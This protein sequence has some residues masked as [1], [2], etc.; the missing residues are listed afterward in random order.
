MLK[1]GL[2]VG[3]T[4]FGALAACGDDDSASGPTNGTTDG[5]V[6]KPN[7]A[8]VVADAGGGGIDAGPSPVLCPSTTPFVIEGPVAELNSDADESGL[9]LTADELTAYFERDK[10]IW[11]ASRPDKNAAF[12]NVVKVEVVNYGRSR[13]PMIARDGKTLYFYSDRDVAGYNFLY[14]ATRGD[15]KFDEPKTVMLAGAKLPG[16]DPY[17]DETGATAYF[18]DSSNNYR[19]VESHIDG[20]GNWGQFKEAEGAN[21]DGGTA[22]TFVSQPAVSVDGL[23]LYFSS[24]QTGASKVYR[25]DRA[26]RTA[27][28][29]AP[30]AL[31]ITQDGDGM[32]WVSDDDCRLYFSRTDAS[33]KQEL[34]LA[35]RK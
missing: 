3:L 31:P 15:A 34:M 32:A 12:A 23:R 21:Y 7:E 2:L 17:V 26:S 20:P 25:S 28:W 10:E 16:I 4:C 22:G 30:A 5:G 19:L 1:R 27:A 18:I 6:V 24:L 29:S 13:E 11:S 33:K 14:L 9:S 35:V 8:G